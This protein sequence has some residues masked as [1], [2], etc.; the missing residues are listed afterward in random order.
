MRTVLSL[1]DGISCGQIALNRAG[2]LYEKYYAS[3]ID[4]SSIKVTQS[5]Y[6]N[7]IQL[8]NI[9]EWKY[10][11]I[12]YSAV[13]LIFAGSPCQGFSFAGKE[14]N[15]DDPR[16]KLFFVFVDILNHAR[17]KNPA[18][19]FVFENVRMQRRFQDVITTSLGV[20]PVSI[21]SA[22]VSAQNRVR[23]YWT[24]LGHVSQPYNTG[25]CL[26]DI[27]EPT[28]ILNNPGL[29]IDADYWS[30]V[31]L[32]LHFYVH[33]L[34][35]FVMSDRVVATAE[36]GRYLSTTGAYSRKGKG[37]IVRGY[38]VRCDHKSYT[39]T[40]VLKD[41]YVTDDLVIRKL[42]PVECE[43][44]QTVPDNYTIAASTSQ[45]YKMLGNAW[46]VDVIVHILSTKGDLS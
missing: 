39:L 45:R 35:L 19:K 5:N 36:R 21:N 16:S 4:K 13:D 29:Q 32:K 28:P 38:E 24:N 17:S 9:L 3:E 12:D 41:C 6:P 46:T 23:L 34:R 22:L 37:D 14:L 43:R 42:T 30:R 15:F 27:V 8:G 31:D 44:L 18:V 1:F 40:T 25:V 10:W 33:K 20:E 2:I 7:T 26:R 11:D